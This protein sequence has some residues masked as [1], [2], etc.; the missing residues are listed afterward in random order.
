MKR[1]F[2]TIGDQ[3][4]NGLW[5]EEHSLEKVSPDCAYRPRQR[6]YRGQTQHILTV[7]RGYSLP[8]IIIIIIIILITLISLIYTSAI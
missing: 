4:V 5:Q 2:S 6:S 7:N 3:C 1:S 8:N